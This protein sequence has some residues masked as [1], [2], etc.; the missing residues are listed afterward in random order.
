MS[1]DT[2]HERAGTRPPPRTRPPQKGRQG[3][4]SGLP[5]AQAVPAVGRRLARSR[6]GRLRCAHGSPPVPPVAR[7][8]TSF[9]TEGPD[10]TSTCTVAFRGC[11]EGRPTTTQMR[12]S[13]RVGERTLA[14]PGRPSQLSATGAGDF[15]GLIPPASRHP[16]R[17]W[18]RGRHTH[19]RTHSALCW[20]RSSLEPAQPVRRVQRLTCRTMGSCSGGLLFST[21]M[22]SH[23][24]NAVS[25][26]A[27][28]GLCCGTGRGVS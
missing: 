9:R 19:A 10:A 17:A 6:E 3:F 7:S 8:F 4:G 1:T 5:A 22:V 21:P 15:E 24:W 27:K 23:T 25:C 12:G 18:P 16:A 28:N 2:G 11:P 13:G 20:Q 26:S 14:P